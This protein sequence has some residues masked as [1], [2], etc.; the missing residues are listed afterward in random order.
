MKIYRGKII[1]RDPGGR[2]PIVSRNIMVEDST[3]GSQRPLALQPSLAL[4]GYSKAGYNWG[5]SG[6][7]PA[8]AALA[9]LL[10]CFDKERAIKFYQVFKWDFL[11]PLAKESEWEIDE[12]LLTDWMAGVEIRERELEDKLKEGANAEDD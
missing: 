4:K 11:V 10:D 2:H 7:G 12:K 3:D 5:Y 6:S 1:R 9:I 8:Q